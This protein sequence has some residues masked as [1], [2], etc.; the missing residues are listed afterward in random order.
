MAKRISISNTLNSL[1]LAISGL[2][3]VSLFLVTR[4]LL[5]VDPAIA[6]TLD[7]H[8]PLL[9]GISAGL[10][11]LLMVYLAIAAVFHKNTRLQAIETLS[12]FTQKMHYF[13]EII[14][15]LLRSKMWLPGLKEY[16]EEEYEGLTFFQVK[17]FYNGKSKLAIE[18][19]EEH[20]QYNDTENLY[21]EFKSLLMTHPL[22]P[23]KGDQV[24]YPEIYDKAIVQQWLR[25]KCGSGLW[26]YF[27]YKYGEFKGALD[28]NAVFERH[29]EKIMNL[30]LSISNDTFQDSSFNEVFL[31]KLGEY[32]N[33]E[34]IPKLLLYRDQ[35]QTNL[36]ALM[37]YL[38]AIF[39]T[40]MGFGVLLPMIALLFQL[41][42]SFLVFGISITLSV[43]VYVALGLYPFLYREANAKKA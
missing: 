42:L 39:V 10:S 4:H 3:A 35:T 2:V 16:L 19:M 29:Q 17:E 11:A 41:S 9:I 1:P 15:I 12:V 43:L 6:L 36:P 23:V 32:M 27:G 31:A 20:H 21:L 34:I 30:A 14:E 8:A 38:Y 25:H 13:R 18:F 28:Y 24:T 22:E 33:Q 7:R 5:T 40:L 37:N 26:Y